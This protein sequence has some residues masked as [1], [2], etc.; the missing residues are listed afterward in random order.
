M[1]EI[2]KEKKTDIWLDKKLEELE[3][4]YFDQIFDAITHD[5]QRMKDAL[6]SKDKIKDDWLPKFKRLTKRRE[7]SDLARGAERV[8]FYLLNV[9]WFPN[10][11]PIGAD[12]FFESHNAF[13]HIDIKT[14]RENNYADFKGIA[15]TSKNQTSYKPTASYL[16]TRINAEPNLPHYYSNGKPCLTYTIQIIYDHTTYE[17]IAILLICIPNGQLFRVY[18]NDIITAGKSKDESF[19]Y[20]YA[21]AP[22]F[23]KLPDNP[24]RVKFIYFNDKYGLTKEEITGKGAEN[25][26]NETQINSHNS[27]KHLGE[28]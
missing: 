11:A 5:Q 22:Y 3:K 16:G 6:T 9:G 26:T 12:L 25:N 23:S 20:K 28:S 27:Q 15:P 21:K 13:I 18:R 1:A 7:T 17:I 2:N 10:S 8:F 4:N 14:A 19:R 24:P